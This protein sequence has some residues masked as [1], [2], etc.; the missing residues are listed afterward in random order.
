MSDDDMMKELVKEEDV[1][2]TISNKGFIKRIPVNSYK[3][4]GRG[5]KGI[6]GAST[7]SSEDDF[8]EHMF[9]GSC[10]YIM[11]FTD[12]GKCYWLKVYDIPEASRT[13]RGKSVLNLIEKRKKKTSRR[14]YGQRFQR[15]VVYH[16]G[17]KERCDKKDCAR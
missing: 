10:Q 7:G 6:K 8:I 16:Y 2:I 9:I 15:A 12:K 4:Q 11:F 5:G 13:S 1:V 14:S 17:N 3:T